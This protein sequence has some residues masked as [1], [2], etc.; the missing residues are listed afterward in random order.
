MTLRNQKDDHDS[1]YVHCQ[2][3]RH[4]KH[5]FRSYGI[6]ASAP[7]EIVYSDI[8]GPF[9]TSHDG[10]K[11]FV[12]LLTISRDSPGYF[13]LN[14][15]TK[16]TTILFESDL[17][18]EIW[19]EL[20]DT[21]IYLKNRAPTHLLEQTP[22]E[23][24]YGMKPD[25]SHLRTI[26]TLAWAMIPSE[27][28]LEKLEERSSSYD[29]M[30]TPN[31]CLRRNRF[32]GGMKPSKLMYNCPRRKNQTRQNMKSTENENEL[33]DILSNPFEIKTAFLYGNLDETI[34]V[35]LSHSFTVTGHVCHIQKSLHYRFSRNS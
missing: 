15:E 11:Y 16:Y 18:K 26:G 5:P 24:L 28:Q 23:K 19:T 4:S 27:K 7:F 34:Y 35:E 25:L 13:A 30:I 22:Y 8:C 9:P 21:T 20:L 14:L 2:K 17:P 6:R 29:T 32:P 12:T 3:A 10:S 31:T 33:F 1:V